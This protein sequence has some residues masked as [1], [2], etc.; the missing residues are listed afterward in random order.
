MRARSARAVA[1]ITAV[2]LLTLLGGC[3]FEPGEPALDIG[4]EAAYNDDDITIPFRVFGMP[5]GTRLRWEVYV[6]DG[7]EFL[8]LWEEA[9][10]VNS[11]DSG[12][13]EFGFLDEGFYQ[14]VF[15]VITSRGSGLDEVPS[16][17]RPVSFYV[18][19][20]PPTTNAVAADF[21]PPPGS[22]TLIG[23]DGRVAVSYDD[24]TDP[25]LLSPQRVLVYVDTAIRP[26]VAGVDEL[27]P[28]ILGPDTR[29]FDVWRETSYAPGTVATVTWV[30]VD[31]AGNRSSLSTGTYEGSP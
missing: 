12:L 14:V 19:R 26:P 27:D 5:P 11:E 24:T 18:D 23:P 25:N 22:P 10:R 20:T 17:R 21:S 1:V 16:L 15:S 9:V 7:S 29:G 6:D 30:V 13:V 31:E 8:L 4:A 28:N 3:L 2:T